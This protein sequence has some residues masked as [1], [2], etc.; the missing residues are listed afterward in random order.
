[1]IYSTF[2]TIFLFFLSS[3]SI[4]NSATEKNRNCKNKFVH[5]TNLKSKADLIVESVYHNLNA[6]EC[7][8]PQFDSFSEALKGYYKLKEKGLVKKEI[9]TLVDFSLSSNTKRLWVIDLA[10]NTILFQSLVA[11]G[12]NTG[13]EFATNFSNKTSSFQSSLGFYVTGE[14]YKGKHGLSLKL[15]GL[16]KLTGVTNLAWAIYNHIASA[17]KGTANEPYPVEQIKAEILAERDSVI[18][19][20]TLAGTL[21][22]QTLIQDINCLELDCENLSLCCKV[23]TYDKVLHFKLPKLASF[24][25]DPIPVYFIGLSDRSHA[26]RIQRGSTWSYKTYNK[27]TK[28][29][30]YVWFAANREDGFLFNPPTDNLKYISVSAIFEDPTQ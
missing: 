14:V 17:L 13:E 2:L 8:L 11:H 24:T 5:T 6:N 15:D 3:F 4:N 29:K 1:M 21:P 7:I 26:F 23:E 16:E 25:V 22:Y 28:D 9:L 20:M 18:K 27:W 19:Q 30:P 10:T 12:R